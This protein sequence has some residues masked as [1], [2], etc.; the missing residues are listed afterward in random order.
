MAPVMATEAKQNKNISHVHKTT[1][2]VG[3]TW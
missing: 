1:T 2:Y 3:W